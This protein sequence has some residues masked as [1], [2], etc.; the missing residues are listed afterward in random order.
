MLH[1]K[2][3]E[4]ERGAPVMTQSDQHHLTLELLVRLR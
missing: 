2:Q 3:S 4:D 1:V